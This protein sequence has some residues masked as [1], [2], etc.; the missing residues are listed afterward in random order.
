MSLIIRR[1]LPTTLEAVD[2]GGTVRGRWSWSALPGHAAVLVQRSAETAAIETELARAA[3]EAFAQADFRFVQFTLSDETDPPSHLAAAGFRELTTLVE[4][5]REAAP[6]PHSESP[7]GLSVAPIAALPF[8]D[9]VRLWNDTLIDTL[10]CPELNEC[11]TPAGLP[12]GFADPLF[13]HA[14]TAFV[15][16]VNG[17]PTGLLIGE[18]TLSDA[19]A[20]ILYLGVVPMFRR[21]GTA[22]ALLAHFPSSLGVAGILRTIVTVDARNIPARRLYERF[23][24]RSCGSYRTWVWINS[25]PTRPIDSLGKSGFLGKRAR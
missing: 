5:S 11:R 24:F 3:V 13:T 21:I 22:S 4:F 20:S 18:I 9:L 2:N 14:H 12:A 17:K 6:M 10:D 23:E 7:V 1:P 15:A 25:S 19:T 16:F 8:V